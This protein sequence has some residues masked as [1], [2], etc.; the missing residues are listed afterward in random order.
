MR[1]LISGNSG[2]VGPCVTRQLRLTWP[3][4]RLI[5][6]DAGYFEDRAAEASDTEQD[7]QVDADIRDLSGSIFNQV[8]AVVHLA[9]LSNDSMAKA[10]EN[11]ADEVNYV[12]TVD[13]AKKAKKAGVKSFVFAS[14]YRVYGASACGASSED[15][16]RT[17]ASP[18]NGGTA[19]SRSKLAA[20]A[21][22]R[23]LAGREFTVTCLRFANACGMSP[24]LR[25][26][27]VLN[28]YVAS[29]VLSGEI[30]VMSNPAAW[31]KLIHVRDMA[32]AIDWA[33]ARPGA[34]GGSHLVLNAGSDAWTMR[35]GELANAVA[36]AIPGVTLCFPREGAPE[37][38]SWRVDFGLFRRLAP[39]HQPREKLAPSV[40]ELKTALEGILARHGKDPSRLNRLKVLSWMVEQG[41]LDKDLRWARGA[42]AAAA[43]RCAISVI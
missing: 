40:V 15:V 35:A 38:G 4:A 34:N 32:R 6:V 26:D 29:A 12:A 18:V 33:V 1:I 39:L 9:A 22:L 31:L 25:L 42:E 24:A 20:E 16:A 10:F 7:R 5:G 13:V 2:Y 19:Y 30:R 41:R 37:T 11:A 21:A 36:D 17:E 28:N 8:D 14:T 3:N 27:T 43:E 23:S